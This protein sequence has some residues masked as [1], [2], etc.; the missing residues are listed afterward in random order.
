MPVELR[1]VQCCAVYDH[2][3]VNRTQWPNGVSSP[4][5]FTAAFSCPLRCLAKAASEGGQVLG[6][7]P[8]HGNSSICLAAL[9]AGLISDTEGG[10]IFVSRFYRH[11]WSGSPSQSVFPYESWQGSVSNGVRSID[12]PPSFYTVP[13]PANQWSYTVRGRGEPV[14]Q[15]RQA[16]FSP[17]SGH[18]HLHLESGLTYGVAQLAWF[19]PRLQLIIGGRNATHYLDDVWAAFVA[20]DLPFV[21]RDGQSYADADLDWVHLSQSPF[22]PRSHMQRF[23]DYLSFRTSSDGKLSFFLHTGG[24]NGSPVRRL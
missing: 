5:L 3:S 24:S 22:S 6:S 20:H 21:G 23:V 13:S 14:T 15:R 16:P 1:P 2:F 7:Y 9:H 18:V 12:V 11:D 4:A 17:R 19:G 10:S 8:Y